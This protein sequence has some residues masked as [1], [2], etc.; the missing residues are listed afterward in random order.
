MVR[1][2]SIEELIHIA[3]TLSG[4]Q[5]RLAFGRG[6]GLVTFGGGNGV[7]AADQ[8]NEEGLP[9]PPLL[10]VTRQRL[11]PLLASV[12]TAANPIDLTPTTAMRE[13]YLS[14]LP[15]ALGVLAEQDDIDT[16]MVIAGTLA[17]RATQIVD[18][19]LAFAERSAK[20]I[21]VAWPSPPKGLREGLAQSGIY[22]FAEPAAAVR[23]M[24]R[25][26]VAGRAATAPMPGAAEPA[27]AVD[28]ASLVPDPQ[29]GLVVPEHR[30]HA[31]LRAAGLPAADGDIATTVDAA[32]AI[33]RRTGF[34]VAMKVLS[35]SVTHRAAAGLLLL[36]IASETELRQGFAELEARA[37][38]QGATLD[39]IYVQAMHGGR[40]ELLVA[41]VRDPL[42]GPMVSVASG[43][44]LT[45]LLD[46]VVTARAPVNVERAAGMIERL[47]V[48][49][50][51]R[52]DAGPLPV[53]APAAFVAGLSA[54][55]AAAPFER[56]VFEANPLKW[57]REGVV[58]VDGLL[59]V[60][61]P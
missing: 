52:D 11:K 46:D 18:A 3:A 58:A 59:I 5:R 17:S 29:P 27:I 12:A 31:I 33:G 16:L 24:A 54:L 13:E 51:A 7:L 22:T 32:V 47:K 42:F 43:G 44:I 23:A 19:I 61:R 30:C 60:D 14:R 26:A 38:R 45:E 20:P 8:C 50:Y 25:L 28:W 37:A 36:G 53:E 56:F 4:Q 57:T 41:A 2:R 39:G 55:F 21:I 15:E 9:T 40:A 6:I 49:C 48:R 10:E 1:A 34:P 35:A